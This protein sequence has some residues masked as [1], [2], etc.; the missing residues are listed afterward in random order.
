TSYN[1]SRITAVSALASSFNFERL[2]LNVAA[3]YSGYIDKDQRTRHAVSPSMDFRIY[4]TEGLG[5][6]GFGRRAYRVPMFN[7]LYYVGY[8][9]PDLL[10]EDAWLADLGL[11]F[12]RSISPAWSIRAKADGFLNHLSNKITSAPTEEDPNIWLPFNIGKVRSSGFD[13]IT[14][15][16]YE[17][18]DWKVY[19]DMKYSYQSAVDRTPG[20][21]S[22]GQQLPY[23]AKHTV[24]ADLKAS[25]KGYSLSPR[26]VLKT[27]RTDSAGTLADWN[28][29]DVTAE[30]E[31]TLKKARLTINLS[32]KNLLN[33]SYELVSGYPMPG[34]SLTGGI[35][36]GF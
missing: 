10:P 26:W 21:H 2:S 34:R 19:M 33:S 16:D 9:N 31:F 35:E 36:F 11:D 18:G 23:L 30:K 6:V 28:T 12:H 3:E 20:S 5:I 25:W 14:G 24:T 13:I 7:E 8:G 1:A 29:L 15:A 17:S 22:C 32:A 27:G 4:I